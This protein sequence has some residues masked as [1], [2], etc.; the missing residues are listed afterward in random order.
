M[1]L[2]PSSYG[3]GESSL[4]SGAAVWNEAIATQSITRSSWMA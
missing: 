4:A 3:G 1:G 2:K